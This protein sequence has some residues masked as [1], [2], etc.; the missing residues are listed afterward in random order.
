MRLYLETNFL[1]VVSDPLDLDYLECLR[2]LQVAEGKRV[3]IVIPHLSMVEAQRG[4]ERKRLARINKFEDV[5]TLI[6]NGIRSGISEAKQIEIDEF[7]IKTQALF[8]VL[9]RSPILE[10]VKNIAK[11]ID[12][13]DSFN[14]V[15][16]GLS[17]ALTSGDKKTPFFMDEMD[18]LVFATVVNHIKSS[19]YTPTPIFCTRDKAM[20]D[21]AK[22]ALTLYPCGL[23]LT[24][25]FKE[26]YEMVKGS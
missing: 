8:D 14:A 21:A 10:R 12:P 13:D 2:I 9:D 22:R 19:H 25:S 18:R 6:R 24:S 3:E 17:A 5:K 15:F 7:D 23:T 26:A 1:Y 11:Q 16:T 20:C 4:Y